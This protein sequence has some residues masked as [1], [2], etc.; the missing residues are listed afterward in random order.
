MTS[1]TAAVDG[2]WETRKQLALALEMGLKVRDGY[3]HTQTFPALKRSF[4]VGPERYDGDLGA[5][6]RGF[7]VLLIHDSKRPHGLSTHSD[8]DWIRWAN[9]LPS[10]RCRGDLSD[11]DGHVLGNILPDLAARRYRARVRFDTAS[12]APEIARFG[13]T[14]NTDP[15]ESRG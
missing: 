5:R 1:A 10:R 13:H 9:A 11:R 6:R 8:Y 15:R 12:G 7:A 3:R 14:H 2:F 4:P